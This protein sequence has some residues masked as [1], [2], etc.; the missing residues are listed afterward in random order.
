ML[1]YYWY[2]KNFKKA[3]KGSCIVVWDR[4]DY[5]SEAEKQL[6]DKA[7]YKD[8]SFNE[9]I[10]SDLVASSNKIF[11]ILERKGAISEKKMKYFL[12]E[13]KNATNLGKLCF[14]P[15]IDSK[16]FNVPER[17][18]I[19][20]CGT[21]TGK[22]SEFLDHQLKPVMQSS[23][24]YIKGSED[25]LRKIKQIG[26]L[27]ENSIIVSIHAD[28]VGLY[29]SIPHELGL[30]ALEEALEK[31]ESKQTSTDDLIKL[32]K[33]VLQNNYFEFNGEIKQQI[34]G[35]DIETKFAPP[36]ACISMDHVESEFLKTQQHQPLVWF[37]YID[38]I[39]FI[40]THGQE[41]LEGFLD[42]FTK[43]HPNLRFTH[44]YSRK[45]VTF[46][47]L[48][49]KIVDRKIFTDLHIKAADRHQYLH[50][51]SSHLY[52]TKRSIVYS[53]ALRVSMI[54]S[55]END[56]IR[57]QNEMKYWF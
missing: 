55:F 27:P 35:T 17:P 18:V 42:Y 40:W 15:K 51:R 13:Y 19:S 34:S 56:F 23:W 6:Y 10:L 21:P 20:N 24:S 50:Y 5:L 29:P 14:L 38:D 45:N 11:K 26:N 44:E 37:R 39:F 31:R 8:V 41:K 28:V 49:V 53:Q 46:L 12:Y 54:Y 2:F 4:D 32:A 1:K 33:F 36:Y 22:G 7:I 52:H 9:K 25:F 16:L 57:H 43:F 47:D 30:K 3:D 48:D